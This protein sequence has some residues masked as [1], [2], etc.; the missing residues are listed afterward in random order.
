VAYSLQ[1]MLENLAPIAVIGSCEGMLKGATDDSRQVC[2]G[3]LFI[4][5]PGEDMDG[6]DYIAQAVKA[7]ASA[8][9]CEQP[10]AVPEGTI[11]VVVK[12]ARHAASRIAHEWHGRPSEKLR[13]VGVT[14]TNGKTTVVFLT[15][16]VLEASG[17]RTGMM[18][19]V[20][21]DLGLGPEPARQTT[22]GPFALHG[23]MAEMLENGCNACVM[24]VSSHALSQARTLDVFFDAAVFTN[25]TGD[26]LDY[27]G[28][29]EAYQEAKARL[30]SGLSADA[31]AVLNTDD[32]TSARFGALTQANVLGY[33]V[34]R[35]KSASN[36][37]AIDP[38]YSLNNIHAHVSSPCAEGEL[39]FP[40]AGR[41]NLY[42]A[43][44][45]IGAGHALGIGLEVSLDALSHTVQ[46]PG[47]LEQVGGEDLPFHVFVDY[48][49]TDDALQSV[50]AA[51]RELVRQRLIVVFGCG[52]DRDRTKRVRMGAVA[53]DFADVTVLTSDN[54]RT[55]APMSIIAEIE[56]GFKNPNCYTV[57]EDRDTAIESALRMAGPGDIV[58]IAG[59]GHEN[60]QDIQ[61]VKRPFDDRKCAQEIL[62][63][64]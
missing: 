39:K 52:G 36:I 11:A 46:V 50:L 62:D 49:H 30:F 56:K 1:Q 48:A 15:R 16:T 63:R 42:N 26:H 10:E 6:H 5:V 24:E 19:T 14:G 27:H 28:T 32:P 34:A 21:N 51:L 20:S 57:E 23:A 45:A 40:L 55:E 35:E 9:V 7:G 13:L 47:R 29:M 33:G 17:M 12:N 53:G 31:W 44:A 41:H 37:T 38:Q 4:A 54:P 25:L 61:G 59:K 43:L 64:L 2:P 8:V 3:G 58:L 60:Y 22:P 18:G